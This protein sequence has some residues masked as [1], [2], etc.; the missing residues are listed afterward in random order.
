MLLI[1]DISSTQVLEKQIKKALLNLTPK[2]STY[3]VNTVS[4]K[5]ILKLIFKYNL[6]IL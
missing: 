4:K 5:E 1:K 3:E 2:E 6:L